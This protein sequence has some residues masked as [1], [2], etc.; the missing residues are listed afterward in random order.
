M[1]QKPQDS[2]LAPDPG[3]T[4]G[5]ESRCRLQATEVL[6]GVRSSFDDWAAL[7]RRL[8]IRVE[9]CVARHVEAYLRS[10]LKGDDGQNLF[11]SIA[12]DERAPFPDEGPSTSNP[13]S[14]SHDGHGL[15]NIN[16]AT[17]NFLEPEVQV[18]GVRTSG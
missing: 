1:P 5:D 17:A 8:E 15:S 9:E 18:L 10:R 2:Q 12:P 4:L 11:V 7:E 6:D 3:A 14:Q 16:F 13:K